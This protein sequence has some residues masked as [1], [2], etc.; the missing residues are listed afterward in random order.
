[1]RPIHCAGMH[2]AL[3]FHGRVPV[4]GYGG[5]QRVV[6]WL[7]RGLVQL[8]H[9]VT[10]LAAEGSQIPGLAVVELDPRATS[11][12]GFD[13]TPFLPGSLDLLHTHAPLTAPPDCPYVFTLHGNLR[14]GRAPGPNTIFLSA[15]HASRHG[16]RAFV[17]NGV[18]PSEFVFRREKGDYDLF[19]G[20]LHSVKGYRW[21]M[22]GAKRS[23]TRLLVA[24]GWR[25]SLRRNLRFVGAV[26][27]ERKADLLASAACLWMPALWEE[28]FGLTLIEA[29]MSGTPVLGTRRGAL[30]EVVTDD[31][32]ALG[33][34]LDELIELRSTIE[35]RDPGACR[36]RAERWFSHTRMAEEYVRMYQHYLASGNLPEGHVTT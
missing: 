23:G 10:L 21:A 25:L 7:A 31:V 33:D 15:D 11:R 26:D 36:A 1:M 29:M 3:Y 13:L 20:R 2:I 28:P 18:D 34:T 9:R 27:G 6:V 22:A 19:L 14:P 32:G 12:P 24:G 17:Y 30:P 35:R 16:A 4:R 5:T 8:G